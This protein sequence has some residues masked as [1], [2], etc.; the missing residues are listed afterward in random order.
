MSL[1]QIWV[2]KTVFVQTLNTQQLYCSL[3][4]RFVKQNLTPPEEAYILTA[5]SS[6]ITT[7]QFQF[8]MTFVCGRSEESWNVI[9]KRI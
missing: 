6:D 5:C 7:A 3:I 1:T 2:K 9:K 8:F 4:E